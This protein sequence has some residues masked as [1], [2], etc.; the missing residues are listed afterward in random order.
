MRVLLDASIH[1]KLLDDIRNIIASHP[2]VIQVKSLVGR[3]AGRFRFIEATIGLRTDNLEKAHS[4]SERIESD[5]RKKISH[6]DRIV[7][8]YEPNPKKE[9]IKAVPL[10]SNKKSLSDHFGEAPYYYIAVIRNSDGKLMEENYVRNPYQRDEK[11]KGIK[12]ARWLI[13]KGVDWVC[14]L[15]DLEGKGPGYVLSDAGV[16][17]NVADHEDLYAI[18]C[19]WE[20]EKE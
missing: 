16:K 9:T 15:S 11:A 17:V 3:N 6:V 10:D 1:P 12:V 14:V 2:A 7:I 4:I 20:K 13:G 5:V 18:K 19:L 8:H